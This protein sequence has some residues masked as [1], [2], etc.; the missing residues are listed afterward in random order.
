M[1]AL[2]SWIAPILIQAL[3]EHLEV[4]ESKSLHVED[5]LSNIYI[6]SD[7]IEFV[8]FVEV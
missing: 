7:S 3:D 1:E 4:T 6:R 5:D 2:R 8:Q